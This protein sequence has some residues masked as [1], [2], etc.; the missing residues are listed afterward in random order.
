MATVPGNSTSGLY[1]LG[2][3]ASAPV[4]NN[5]GDANVAVFLGVFQGNLTA[6]QITVETGN[7]FGNNI[8]TN[9]YYWANGVPLIDT[10]YSNVNTEQ[11]LPTYTGNIGGTI[12]TATQPYIT[13]LPP[14]VNLTAASN[15]NIGNFWINNL[16]D[17]INPQDAATKNYVDGIAQG[18]NVHSS[19]SLATT[20]P[21][22]P[23]TYNNGNQGV[24]AT[25]QGLS[26]SLLTID[27]RTVLPGSR[28]LIKNE[29]GLNAPYNGIYNCT[30]NGI[31]ATFLLTR[32]S[33]LNQPVDF[34][35]AYAFVS[36]GIA[37]LDS[38]WL[39][40]NNEGIPI[41]IGTTP[42]VWAQFGQGGSYLNGNGITIN[43]GFI[44]VNTDTLTN[45][46]FN[47]VE[48][49]IAV[50]PNLNLSS[51]TTSGN[52]T[53][54]GYVFGNIAYATGQGA[55]NIISFGNS[56]VV[57]PVSNGPIV[58]SINNANAI[59]LT[60]QGAVTLGYNATT[61]VTN[62]TITIGGNAGNAAAQASQAIAIGYN[63]AKSGQ[64]LYAVAIGQSAALGT[65]NA[66]QGLASIALGLNAARAGQGQ[67]S[68]A[69]GVNAGATNQGNSAVAIGLQSGLTQ[70]TQS[71][72]VGYLAGQSQTTNGIAIGTQSGSQSS[73]QSD[74]A[75]AIGTNAGAT[76]QNI[77]TI[78]IG[79]N[80]AANQV[81]QQFQNAIAVGVNSGYTLQGENSVAVGTGA[82][83]I[84]QQA[85]SVAIGTYAGNANL[86]L[87][88]VA[89]GAYAG[90]INQAAYSIAIN[91]SGQDLNPPNAGFFAAPV[92][93]DPGNV[94]Q[95]VFFNTAT[96][97][98]T[99]APTGAANIPGITNGG[100]YL[101]VNSNGTLSMSNSGGTGP[102]NFNS[103]QNSLAWGYGAGNVTQAANSVAIG[104]TAGFTTQG[105]KSVAIGWE[106]G[107][108]TQG[109][110][111]IALGAQSGYSN[112]KT[113]SIAIGATAGYSNQQN[114]A[115]AIGTAAGYTTQGTNSIAI[116]QLAG[117][118]NQVA[119][120]IA[121]NASGAA[122]QAA[123]PGLFINPVR[124]DSNN[125]MNVM[126][127]NSATNE[128]T[129]SPISAAI[130]GL[131]FGGTVWNDVTGSRSSGTTYTNSYSYP[132]AVSATGTGA[133]GPS[134][135]AYVDGIL[136]SD[137]NWQFNGAGAHSGAFI[138]VPPGS[139]YELVFNGSGI[140]NWVELY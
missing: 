127:F 42:I 35:G 7:I 140:Q 135:F 85:Q 130:K 93:S 22:P 108:T 26:N 9:E 71:I 113:N 51:V 5:Y 36:G 96:N 44:N 118:T 115:I 114:Q 31:G 119:H 4:G 137:F 87:N 18:L 102:A 73:V 39:C 83:Q 107:N 40:I 133:S 94:T 104:Y 112:Q 53:A 79:K 90:N 2:S 6:G 49:Q 1:G 88:S 3:N 64:G 100:G 77:N 70:G 20:A 46:T 74:S 37:N 105:S 97:E 66:P 17:P 11:F 21:L 10:L 69:I 120:S 101:V 95:A 43:N 122:L 117:Q 30:R 23:Y 56:N 134:I 13:A 91:A 125:T 52:V 86:G 89:I 59:N 29:T 84:S 41:I 99:Y 106:A 81:A 139:T 24:G 19:V 123:L 50:N 129:Y 57:I 33:D 103:Q 58:G 128:I 110:T 65:N 25:I 67:R 82:G 124:A 126:F 16:R 38:S 75:I 55:P 48:N 131:G 54:N 12:T 14:Q 72:A 45:T 68:V 28:V 136:V 138:I 47:N 34:Y 109:A 61:G 121:I 27:G 60:Q 63:S 132:I 78:A 111:S 32:S 15:V 80:A 116:G 76:A 62:D 98:F 8:L 92:R